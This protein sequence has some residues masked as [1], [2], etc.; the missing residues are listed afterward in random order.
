MKPGAYPLDEL[1]IA[2]TR[3]AAN[4]TANL[5]EHL[6]RDG[7]GL[8]RIASL[9][10]PADQSELVIIID[11]FEEVF[12]LVEDEN[13]R[14]HFINLI[15]QSVTDP[16][17][18]VRIIITLRADFYDRPLQYAD[19]GELVRSRMETV[20]PLSA[21]ELEAAIAK[22][23]ARVGVKFETGL[24]ATIVS[25]IHYQPGALPLLQ[26]ALTELFEQ[27]VNH[28]LTHE[29]YTALGGATGALAKRAEEL[30][31]EQNTDGQETIRQIFLHLVSLGE[32]AE[33][34]RRRVLRAE[35][36]ELSD[37]KELIDEMLDTYA[38]YR[39][40]TLDHDPSSRRPTV[41]IAHEA[42]LR[43]WERLRVW[44]NDS[45]YDIRQ[46][47]M[48][49]AAAAEWSQSNGDASYLL[50]GARLEQMAGWATES[51]LAL[52]PHERKFLETS[53]LERT[54]Q[55]NDEQERQQ[56][57]L[58]TQR[59]LAEQQRQSANR[60]RYLVMGLAVFLVTA[61]ALL[62]YA[63]YQGQQIEDARG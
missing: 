33:D 59:Q 13:K 47:Q 34:T 39:L 38:A 28:T 56:R 27:R 40:L 37:D 55:E 23:A 12:T 50:R 63:F 18:R 48:L 35:L 14:A 2:L 25:D 24:I 4:Q 3:V 43:E 32:G 58:T 11:Q 44:L 6:E 1:E 49:S 31:H 8:V 62:F 45:R 5:R 52:T 10:L 15:C 60:L 53:L 42:I 7:R 21:D 17:S 41:E 22:P 9:I 26:Y 51:K 20:M 46:Q 54:R 61:I 29:A 19:F 36:L 16:R 30:Y 57:E